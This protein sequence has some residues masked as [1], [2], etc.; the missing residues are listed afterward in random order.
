MLFKGRY[1]KLFK[2]PHGLFLIFIYTLTVIA[3]GGTVAVLICE[4]ITPIC[5]FLSYLLYGVTAALLTYSVY[6]VILYAPEVKSKFITNLKK[7]PFAASFIEHYGYKTSVMA[8]LSLIMTAAFAVTNSVNAVIYSSGWYG[9]LAGYYFVLV[10]SRGGIL[11]A[12]TVCKRKYS[13]NP[14]AYERA[15][16][17]IYLG[18]GIFLV[19]LEFATAF[20][21]YQMI[22]SGR[23]SQG[24]K[25]MAIITAA[26]TFI[27]VSFAIYNL[28]KARKFENPV[29]QSL[30]NIGFADG[31]TSVVS[32]TVL[33]LAIFGEKADLPY[34]K[35]AVGFTA[36]AAIIA[37]SVIMIARAA[38]NLRNTKEGNRNE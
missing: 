13:Q 34:V 1:V 11:T 31:C 16:W 7:R 8:V 12:D 21:I 19:L 24:G 17:H 38:V 32:L 5:E 26:Y 37:L 25:V 35:I 22:R 23:P 30:R 9:T 28:I 6:T 3:V 10:I 29:T 2:R 18:C 4:P 36:C 33:M 15:K 20:T 27:K 14:E